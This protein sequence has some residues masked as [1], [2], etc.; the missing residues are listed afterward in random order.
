[1]KVLAHL[2]PVVLERTLLDELVEFLPHG[3][4]SAALVIVP[5]R[6]LAG[7]LEQRLL[8]RRPAWLGLDVLHFN[9]LAL[10][11]L[12]E[13]GIPAP[14]MLS[15]SLIE[16]LLR[17]V[18]RRHPQNRWSR[19]VRERPG[20]L[21]GLASSLRDLRE[22]RVS[23]DTLRERTREDDGG[24]DLAPLYH[25]LCEELERLRGECW[26]DDAGLIEAALPHAERFAVRRRGIWL[27]GAYELTGLH[28]QLVCSLDRGRE[29]RALFP[30]QENAPVSR[31]AERF[32][33]HHLRS[34]DGGDVG[35]EVI[36]AIDPTDDRL[37]LA[38]LYDEGARPV[39]AEHPEIVYRS[40]Q[41]AAAEIKGAVRAALAEVGAGCPPHEIVIVARSLTPYEAALDEV[42]EQEDLPWTGSLTQ[43]LRN[44]P[45][46]HDF[47][48]L[49][50][51]LDEGFPRRGTAEL[52]RSP[53]IRWDR[54]TENGAPPRGEYA[55]RW[56]RAAGVVSGLDEWSELLVEW[57]G[58][59]HGRAERS[60]EEQ[61]H[62][63][64]RAA[65]RTVEAKLIA[66]TLRRLHDRMRPDETRTWSGHAD[67]LVALI[68]DAFFT[69]G[70]VWDD[71]GSLL[72]EMRS[73]ETIVGEGGAVSF[74]DMRRW[75]ETAID[76]TERMPHRRDNGGIR[77]LDMMQ[78]RGI[79]C[80]RLFVVGMNSGVLPRPPRPDP[81]L[82][83]E[84]REA[85]GGPGTPLPVKKHGLEEERLLLNLALGAATERIELTWQRADEAGRGRTPSLALRETARLS[86][87]TPEL[88][89]CLRDAAWH[90]SHPT[91]AL[92]WLQRT[93]GMLS[94]REERLL[95]TLQ[96]IGQPAA[97]DDWYPELTPGL[98]LLRATESFKFHDRSFDGRIGA[99]E[100]TGRP[101]SVS[102]L[103]TLARCPLQFFFQR[104]LRVRE[105]DEEA[106][107]FELTPREIGQH[108]HDLLERT[109]AMLRTEGLFERPLADRVRRASEIL[110]EVWIDAWRT[111]AQRLSRRAPALWAAQEARWKG[112]VLRFVVE[113]LERIDAGGWG[114]P[115]TEQAIDQEV[116]FGED[117]S[118]HLIGRVDRSF[119]DPTRR[120]IGDYK[121]GKVEGL[122]N[123]TRMLKAQTLQVPLYWMLAETKA[124]I[125]VL[126]VGPRYDPA[127][128]DAEER[129]LNFDGLKPDEFSGFIETMRVLTDLLANGVFP[130]KHSNIG[131]R[132]CAYE[133]S[134]RHLHPPT[135][136][137]EEHAADRADFRDLSKKSKS[138]KQTLEKA[139][140]S[141]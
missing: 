51:V 46:I 52:L 23:S 137:R 135:L 111:L 108:T 85:L 4:Q 31:Y 90:P 57:A 39:P 30:Y 99:A 28:T 71:I 12:A 107:P 63:N 49:V 1:M 130:L 64:Q 34:G 131:C 59:I 136:E 116:P 121:T 60:S 27:H 100:L 36:E 17:G 2:D 19:Y 118:L 78:L 103:E 13:T 141:R 134:C 139:R 140:A 22:A 96:S 89:A 61:E 65:E 32:L 122:T 9:A 50:A 44:H 123:A 10:R 127:E 77:V 115:E 18:L 5:T 16:A 81:V 84:L 56:S 42:F 29:V 75:L 41:G 128:V 62:E 53:R 48:L 74:G 55:D 112:A 91:L 106:E 126:G 133:L 102:A 93:A 119:G 114:V 15:P 104:V 3:E 69:E 95:T 37:P 120:V 129:V 82:P 33:K 70:D 6:R 87:G 79:T 125:E 24:R 66:A 8:E 54:F 35:I 67:Q 132:Y 11:I 124:K 20:A 73:L 97:L 7:H 94:A 86:H 117:R 14:R 21:S 38:A 98:N 109:Y 138:K 110:D 43:P 68:A 45:S 25:G 101:W 113:D 47:A 58:R 83:D 88:A 72:S 26:M 80:R 40:A 105:F 92:E 76:R